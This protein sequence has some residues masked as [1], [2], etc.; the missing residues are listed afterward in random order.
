MQNSKCLFFFWSSQ[1]RQVVKLWSPKCKNVFM[2]LW[3]VCCVCRYVTISGLIVI[4]GA[5]EQR[6]SYIWSYGVRWE[7]KNTIW[8]CCFSQMYQGKNLHRGVGTQ[9]PL[10]ESLGNLHG[11]LFHISFFLQ[12]NCGF[13]WGFGYAKILNCHWL[14]KIFIS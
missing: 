11:A 9:L 2:C 5:L 10:S 4:C 7:G 13:R 8:L 12:E 3:K 14:F 6:A 1:R